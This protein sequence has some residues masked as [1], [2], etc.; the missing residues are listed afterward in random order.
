MP[1]STVALS[2]IVVPL[3]LVMSTVSPKLDAISVAKLILVLCVGS[4]IVVIRH[5]ANVVF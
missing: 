3:A 2:F 4:A 5:P 1:E